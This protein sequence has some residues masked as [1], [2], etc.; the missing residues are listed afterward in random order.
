MALNYSHS[1]IRS[2]VPTFPLSEVR[3]LPALEA[4]GVSSTLDKS[5][6]LEL[7]RLHL[8]AATTS[9]PSSRSD[10]PGKSIPAVRNR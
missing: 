2:P 5:I 8:A 4:L 6:L 9:S 1:C 7:A 10:Q 3:S